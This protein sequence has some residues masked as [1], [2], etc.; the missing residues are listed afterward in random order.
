MNCM[1][2]RP[3]KSTSPKGAFTLIEL[4]V[5]IAIIAILAGLL[6][7]ALAKAKFRAKVTN[8]TSNYRQWGVVLTMYAGDDPQ[9]RLPSF[10]VMGSPDGNPWDV[11]P[12]MVTEL[13]PY[14]LTVP[15]WF[16]PVRPKEYLQYDPPPATLEDLITLLLYEDD[17]SRFV[18]IYHSWWGPRRRN[19]VQWFPYPK[20]EPPG[21]GIVLP[22]TRTP[23]D[24]IPWPVKA[25]D[26]GAAF[27]P[28]ITDRCFGEL[29]KDKTD[30]S[31]VVEGASGHPYA[32]KVESLNA[33]FSDG[34]VESRRRNALVWRYITPGN[35][36]SYY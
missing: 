6:L 2:G 36:T 11:S 32:G 34:H 13:G 7:P 17:P 30:F 20:I 12:K 18:T 27:Q 22:S 29:T 14:G 35:T 16:C 23:K 5:V 10:D 3:K 21:P 31:N 1:S 26:Q 15:M 8:C 24:A 4:L 19:G 33:A 28:I 25:S 9:G